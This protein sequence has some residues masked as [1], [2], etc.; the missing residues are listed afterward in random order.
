[1]CVL[2]R[3]TCA[4]VCVCVVWCARW[5]VRGWPGLFLYQAFTSGVRMVL[6]AAPAIAFVL[7]IVPRAFLRDVSRARSFAALVPKR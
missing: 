2:F 6:G 5:A 4:Y 1:M 7:A 3:R